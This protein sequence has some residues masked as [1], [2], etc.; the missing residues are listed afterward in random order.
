MKDTTIDNTDENTFLV[1]LCHVGGLDL[2]TWFNKIFIFHGA[3][4]HPTFLEDYTRDEFIQENSQDTQE[5]TM[6]LKW[7]KEYELEHWFK[8]G[9]LYLHSTF[10]E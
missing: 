4:L 2:S 8:R 5:E 7:I 1:D 3:K 10:D 9:K 6:L